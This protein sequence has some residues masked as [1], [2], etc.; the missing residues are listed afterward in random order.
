MQSAESCGTS[1]Q[2]SA[3]LFLQSWVETKF[4]FVLSRGLESL[5]FLC[6]LA[7]L[8]CA[9]RPSNYI[10]VPKVDKQDLG[11]IEEAPNYRITS[12]NLLM[13]V[14]FGGCDTNYKLEDIIATAEKCLTNK[15]GVILDFDGFERRVD[16]SLPEV[17]LSWRFFD[18]EL[19]NMNK[20]GRQ[21][22]NKGIRN[23]DTWLISSLSE[24]TKVSLQ[25][26]LNDPVEEFPFRASLVLDL[27]KIIEGPLIYDP[28]RFEGIALSQ[29]VKQL[30]LHNPRGQDLVS[31]NRLLLADAYPTELQRR[32]N[33]FDRTGVL[34]TFRRN[35]GELYYSV[36]FD[37]DGKVVS[38][39]STPY[40]R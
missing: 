16:L 5:G 34:V 17:T 24:F 3:I 25:R 14:Y 21:L 10:G 11:Q 38:V 39:D 7:C 29:E 36:Y 30:R 23:I 2:H 13:F 8:G 37:S 4:S 20:M 31:L 12:T 18:F 35:P 6:L 19:V 40:N 27:N 22:A 32:P 9:M 28:K 26:Y 15:Y 33:R 1:P